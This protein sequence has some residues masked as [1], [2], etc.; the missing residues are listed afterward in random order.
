MVA[1][2]ARRWAVPNNK[3]FTSEPVIR[4]VS[5][6]LSSVASSR[7]MP[8]SLAPGLNLFTY[9]AYQLHKY[10]EY[11]YC[12]FVM[13][14]GYSFGPQQKSKFRTAKCRETRLAFVV[15]QRGEQ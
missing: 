9:N 4:E 2:K 11:C 3:H 5:D 13:H 10:S 8:C 7:Q 1:R 15:F 14:N 12:R 6:A